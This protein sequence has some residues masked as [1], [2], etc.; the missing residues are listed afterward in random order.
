MKLQLLNLMFLFCLFGCEKDNLDHTIIPNGTYVGTFQRE[1][2][3]SVGDSANISM[4]FYSNTWSGSSNKTNFPALCNGTYDITG[5]TILF[6]NKCDWKSD[7]NESL[8]LSGKYVIK[9][10]GNVIEFYKDD[11]SAT[12]DTYIDI[13]KLKLQ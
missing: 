3:W 12:S 8:I 2:V 7:F 9:I 4:V 13:Y 11:R 6:E 5:D 1:P 10:E